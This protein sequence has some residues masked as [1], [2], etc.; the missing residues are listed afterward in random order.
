[1]AEKFEFR[2]NAAQVQ[3]VQ[4]ALTFYL[5]ETEEAEPCTDRGRSLQRMEEVSTVLEALG[6][7]REWVCPK[8]GGDNLH[9]RREHPL[10]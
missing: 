10:W 6:F 9:C 7:E 5:Q 2:F 1:M 4:Q 8:C 3:A